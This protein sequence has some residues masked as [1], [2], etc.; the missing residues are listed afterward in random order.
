MVRY[1]SLEHNP[2][3]Q[4]NIILSS[5][6][7]EKRLLALDS[8]P[9]P[10]TLLKASYNLHGYRPEYFIGWENF[11]KHGAYS[12]QR[13]QPR[14]WHQ[15]GVIWDNDNI[16]FSDLLLGLVLLI[17]EHWLYIA[18]YLSEYQWKHRK[19]YIVTVAL[20]KSFCFKWFNI[21][22]IPLLFNSKHYKHCLVKK[23]FGEWLD[24]WWVARKEWGLSVRADL[25]NR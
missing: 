14:S 25:H 18:I 5:H 19:M 22:L 20:G 4:Q 8:A 13:I 23:T 9:L 24:I 11:I 7:E 16:I 3:W 6:A 2:T 15:F 10:P 21:Y 1:I 12:R 17:Y